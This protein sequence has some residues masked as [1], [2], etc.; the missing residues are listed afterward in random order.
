VPAAIEVC[1]VQLEYFLEAGK[2]LGRQDRF[3]AASLEHGDNL[4]LARHTVFGFG[5]V[6]LGLGKMIEDNGFVHVTK[7]QIRAKGSGCGNKITPVT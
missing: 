3:E 1:G 2:Q 7:A 4:A 6:P 5:D